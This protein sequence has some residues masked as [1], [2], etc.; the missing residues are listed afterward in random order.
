MSLS[1]NSEVDGAADVFQQHRDELGF[2]NR[3]QCREGDLYTVE[4]D[5]EIVG[6]ALG[7]HCVRKPQTTLYE[8]A[9]VPEFR[10]EGI[11]TQLVEKMVADSPHEKLVAKC[12]VGL[13]SNEFYEETGW[14]RIDREEGKNRALNVWEYRIPE[15]PDFITT[16]RPDLTDIAASYGWLRGSRLDDVARYERLGV[17]LDFID[18]HWEDPDPD[19]LL[20]ATM[21]HRPKYVVAGDY[22]GD[23]ITEINEQAAAL[24][25]YAEN[26]IIV[27]H[28]SGEVAEVPDWAV[29]GYSTPTGYA[30]TDA[31]VWEYYGRDVHILGGTIGQIKEVYGY[32]RNE[33][34]SIDTNSFHRGATSYAKWWGRTSP[35]WNKLAEPVAK[36]TNAERAYERSLLNLSYHLREQGLL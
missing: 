8:L 6:A 33:V 34:V 24:Q 15:K 4:R 25:R 16:G 13:P 21:R 5:G 18:L 36:P 17:E 26:V 2:V 29:V 22:D 10:R 11:A 28:Q 30:G 9:V 31:P 23:N 35:Q 12:P 32:L 7:N 27:P 20:A 14:E 19:A 3:A 1:V